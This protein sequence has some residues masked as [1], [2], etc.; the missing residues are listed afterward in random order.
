MDAGDAI[1]PL[2]DV[3]GLK[4]GLMTCYDL[5]FPE[6]ALAHALQGAEILVLPAA[7]V[8][9]SLKEHHWSTLWLQER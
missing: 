6:L 1:A 2:L 9:G 5:R 4:V 7:R 8:R 3:G